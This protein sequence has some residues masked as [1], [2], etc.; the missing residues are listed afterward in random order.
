MNLKHLRV[1]RSKKVLRLHRK[2]TCPKD[3]RDNLEN[4]LN[5]QNCLSVSKKPSKT[6]LL[7]NL[8]C[9]TNT[10]ERVATE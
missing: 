5:G 2:G 10:H 6:L 8:R 7:G 1:A 9:S 3:S 4:P